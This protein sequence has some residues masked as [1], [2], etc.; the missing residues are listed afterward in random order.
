MCLSRSTV[1]THHKLF[2]AP[3]SASIAHRRFIS[4]SGRFR[5]CSRGDSSRLQNELDD[6]ASTLSM[7]VTARKRRSTS[8]CTA[9]MQSTL[10]ALVALYSELAWGDSEAAADMRKCAA[11]WTMSVFHQKNTPNF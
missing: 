8:F 11:G 7:Y 1:C 6:F 10:A 2:L 4:S 5:I 3:Y 9:T